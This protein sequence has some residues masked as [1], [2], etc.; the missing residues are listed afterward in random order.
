MKFTMFINKLLDIDKKN[1]LTL[2][3]YWRET[4]RHQ[5]TMYL[6]FHHIC[7]YILK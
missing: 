2:E 4:N 5:A 7:I 1:F 6:C 3:S